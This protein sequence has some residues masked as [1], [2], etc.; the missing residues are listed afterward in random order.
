MCYIL[1]IRQHFWISK[2]CFARTIDHLQL[3]T[4]NKGFW[5]D[6][7]DTIFPSYLNNLLCLQ[8]VSP[9]TQY[10]VALITT[11]WRELMLTEDL[12]PRSD[13]K[14][15]SKTL[16]NWLVLLSAWLVCGTI[17]LI[18]AESLVKSLWWHLTQGSCYSLNSLNT[19]GI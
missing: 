3:V 11:S 6:P 9:A 5:D 18:W 13:A 15:V 10:L 19:P 17:S 1:E 16:N 7:R 12:S 2:T 14:M 4:K 8:I